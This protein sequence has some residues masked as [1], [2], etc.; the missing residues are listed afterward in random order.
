MVLHLIS[1]DLLPRDGRYQVLGGRGR[2]GGGCGL[3]DLGVVVASDLDGPP[4]RGGGGWSG[5]R[6]RPGG[7]GGGAALSL[8]VLLL[9]SQD[10][11]LAA[12]QSVIYIT[13]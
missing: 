13:V 2:L 9:L 3:R 5:G 8:L 6:G 7:R 10:I 1:G 11:S 4:K 12:G